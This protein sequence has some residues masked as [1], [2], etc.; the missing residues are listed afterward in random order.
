MDQLSGAY[1]ICQNELGLYD[2]TFCTYSTP[3]KGSLKTH[4]NIHTKEQLYT[5][6][7]CQKSFTDKI[8][9]LSLGFLNKFQKRGLHS[10]TFCTYSTPFK[11]SL[12]KHI[13]THTK[14]RLF[15]CEVCQ[16][17]FTDISNLKQHFRI[18]TGEKPYK[19]DICNKAFNQSSTLRSHKLIHLKKNQFM[20]FCVIGTSNFSQNEQGLYV[21]TFC[22]YSTP[23]RRNFRNHINVHTKERLYTC[24]V[25]QKSFTDNS[26]LKQHFRIH[27]GEKPYKC[28]VCN[29][30]FNQSS[31][32]RIHKMVVHR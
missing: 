32:L 9:F 27:T 16:K 26:N 31:N 14:E 20:L 23:V 28:E 2:C 24:G 25:C 17:S 13:N 22:T 10:C 11:G 30:A 8:F 21:C 1:D 29:K 5:C 19:C 4:I 12:K 6:V 18:H 7:V 15:A 3:F